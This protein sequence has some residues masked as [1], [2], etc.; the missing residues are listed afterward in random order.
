VWEAAGITGFDPTD[1]T[2]RELEWAAR[3]KRRDAWDRAAR[4]CLVIANAIG[5]D[6]HATE[7]D[8]HPFLEDAERDEHYMTE[9]E[10]EAEARAAGVF[11][12]KT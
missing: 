12:E 9:E 10:A 11:R 6:S 3:A 2:L 8:F 5:G 4:I 7:A 1:R